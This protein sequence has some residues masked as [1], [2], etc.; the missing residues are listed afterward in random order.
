MSILPSD[1]RGRIKFVDR[2]E[3]VKAV[4]VIELVAESMEDC[5]RRLLPIST[6]G[7]WISPR[8]VL[9]CGIPRRNTQGVRL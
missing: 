4:D 5:P 2:Q 6:A 7:P 9:R 1:V 8:L 3:S